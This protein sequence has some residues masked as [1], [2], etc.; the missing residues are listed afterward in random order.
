[1][2]FWVESVHDDHAPRFLEPSDLCHLYEG[3]HMLGA[4]FD[5]AGFL[6]HAGN[7]LRR[8]DAVPDGPVASALGDCVAAAAEAD[9]AGVEGLDSIIEA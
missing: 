6:R 5:A 3:M 4:P 1:D 2:F 7:L 8:S 9:A